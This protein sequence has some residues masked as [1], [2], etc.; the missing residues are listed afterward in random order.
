MALAI[1]TLKPTFPAPC[2]R[3]IHTRSGSYGGHGVRHKIA[4]AKP[5]SCPEGWDIA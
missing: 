4:L 2:A 1:E 5:L 3:W